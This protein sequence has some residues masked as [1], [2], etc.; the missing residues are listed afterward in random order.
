MSRACLVPACG[1]GSRLI[2][3]RGSAWPK[4]NPTA[5]KYVFG[6][7]VEALSH[8]WASFPEWRVLGPIHTEPGVAKR[9]RNV[10]PMKLSVFFK[11]QAL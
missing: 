4:Y 8:A 5:D 7:E 1:G 11:F 6:H 9:G 10:W 2:C 3:S